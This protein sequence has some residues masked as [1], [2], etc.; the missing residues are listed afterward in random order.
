MNYIK[1]RKRYPVFTYESF[2]YELAGNDLLMNFSYAIG[3]DIR[4]NPLT[5][6]LDV[7]KSRFAKL[8]EAAI[9]NFVFHVGLVEMISYWKAT[10]SPKIV[11]KAGSLND[12]Q[13]SWWHKLIMNGMGEYFYTNKIDF[14][15]DDFLQIE[16]RG[17]SINTE[18]AR[19]ES[20]KVLVPVSGGKDS[21]VTLATLGRHFNIGTF[22]HSP[23]S[24]AADRV[25]DASGV[26]EN[27]SGQM[28]IKDR[29]L[30][31]NEQGF[32]NG[33]VPYSA[34]LAIVSLFCAY[35][36][37]YGKVAFSNERSSNEDNVVYLGKSINHQ[38]S[39]TFEFENLFRKYNKKYLSNIEY[40]S[41]LRPLY[42]I[43]IA[44]LFTKH[45]KYFK[46][47]RSCN[48]G[49]KDDIW[50]CEC[51]KCLSTFVLFYAFLGPTR[52][53]EIF[54]K[55]MF[56]DLGLENLLKSLIDESLPKPFEC[57]GTRNELRVGLY[58]STKYHNGD[59]PPLLKA[60]TG[61]IKDRKRLEKTSLYLVNGWD[62]NN[63]LPTK[64]Q[65]ILR[66]E[67]DAKAT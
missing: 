51:P 6:V 58:L 1:I 4:F 2:H 23:T 17:E 62:D 21:T 61:Y 40:F 48:K 7:D 13:V 24:R 53:L 37:G 60:A 43:Q 3:T 15:S 33:H 66:K 57:V 42:D 34:Y 30:E 35:L 56:E 32:L 16:S 26:K 38:Y 55:N 12:D 18:A 50:C 45:P 19:I 65:D 29:L 36:F 9:G 46:I 28:R 25:I 39:K 10:A 11:V 54:P 41:F 22:T 31:M 67:L 52:I 14:T 44:K 64:F 59:F 20:D 5:V 49:Q 47:F 63:N 27:I 8:P